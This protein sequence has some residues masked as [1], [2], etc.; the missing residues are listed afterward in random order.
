MKCVNSCEKENSY[1]KM[2]N[3]LML[4]NEVYIQ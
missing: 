2:S 3:L 1:V 4:F